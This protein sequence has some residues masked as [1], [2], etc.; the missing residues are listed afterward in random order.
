M[1]QLRKCLV[2][3]VLL[4]GI[5]QL[6]NG[7][8]KIG[9]FNSGVLLQ[10][11]PAVKQ[12]NSNLEALS[13]QLQKKYEGMVQ[14][15]QAKYQDLAQKKQ[16]GELSPKQEQDE[17]AKLQEEQTK[18]GQQEQAMQLE[19]ENK[20]KELLQPIL[21]DV[22]VKVAEVAKENG[23]SYIMDE[24]TGVLLFKDEAS[25]VTALVKAKLGLP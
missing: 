8:T 15:F 7:Q 16:R 12:A 22:T 6:A 5:G 11:I 2:L 14:E 17:G 18:I 1:N 13:G 23:F 24:G 20:R 19:L 10:E 21:D 9:Y 25:D 3:A 4:L